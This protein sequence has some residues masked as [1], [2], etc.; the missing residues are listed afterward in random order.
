M[1]AIGQ[2]IRDVV[3]VHPEVFDFGRLTNWSNPKQPLRYTMEAI[4]PFISCELQAP[5]LSIFFIPPMAF[6]QETQ[7]HFTLNSTRD[8]PASL[9][10]W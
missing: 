5:R 7:L 9:M 2:T 8:R 4:R 10:K 3:T 1:Q 6:N